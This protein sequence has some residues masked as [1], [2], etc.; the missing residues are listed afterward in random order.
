[1]SKALLIKSYTTLTTGTQ[2]NWNDLNMA[3][4]YIQGIQTEDSSSRKPS[5]TPLPIHIPLDWFSG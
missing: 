4:S 3:S 5:N 2:G 1:M